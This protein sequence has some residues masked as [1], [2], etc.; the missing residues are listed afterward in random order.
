MDRRLGQHEDGIVEVVGSS[1]DSVVRHLRV[2]EVGA[3]APQPAQTTQKV[4]VHPTP[5]TSLLSALVER[6][7]RG[8]VPAWS[9]LYQ[10]TYDVVFRHVC[11]LT[12]DTGL[13]EDLTQDVFARAMSNIGQ[14]D[15]QASFAAWLRGIALNVVRM[16]WRSARNGSTFRSRLENLTEAQDRT[17]RAPDD[18]HLRDQKMKVLYEVLGTLPQSLR[19]AFVLRDLEGLSTQEAGDQLG[20]SAGNVAVRASRA[21][22]RIRTELQ[23][24][25]WIHGGGK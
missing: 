15:G 21:R 23:K 7:R 14:Y 1:R 6:A 9:R 13:S 19:E 11:Y 10:E 20:I 22:A 5:P 17:G 3:P 25:G 2:P 16:H 12:G 8:D 24:M 18:L 4:P